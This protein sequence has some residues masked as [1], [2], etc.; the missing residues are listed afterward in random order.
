MNRLAAIIIPSYI[1]L[2]VII[3]IVIGRKSKSTMKE[4]ALGGGGLPWYVTAGTIVASLV[5][6]GTM[7]GYVG[8]Y[9]A[10]GM[11]WVWMGVGLSLAILF[12]AFVT[13]PRI[14]NL[15]LTSVAEIFALRYG[16]NNGT[17]GCISYFAGIWRRRY[18]TDISG[19]FAGKL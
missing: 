9:Y 16:S 6:G 1:V 7:I 17:N 10:F 11:E 12:I 5:G 18:L 2:M 14:K 4:Y 8:S 19:Y 13:G 3:M 15:D